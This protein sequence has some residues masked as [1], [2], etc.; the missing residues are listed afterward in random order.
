[1]KKHVFPC[2]SSVSL[3]SCWLES[4]LLFFVLLLCCLFLV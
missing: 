4:S 1:M 2:N 3:E